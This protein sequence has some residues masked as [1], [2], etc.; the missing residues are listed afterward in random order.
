M[1]VQTVKI[2][3]DTMTSIV[4]FNIV[5]S[6]GNLAAVSVKDNLL[7]SQRLKCFLTCMVYF[8]SGAQPTK[9]AQPARKKRG[10]HDMAMADSPPPSLVPRTQD[11]YNQLFDT[12]HNQEATQIL[13]ALQKTYTERH[14]GREGHERV[15]LAD[16]SL[17]DAF[18]EE[19]LKGSGKTV[20]VQIEETFKAMHSRVP[21]IQHFTW[22]QYHFAGMPL[23]NILTN[24]QHPNHPNHPNHFNTYDD[25]I[26]FYNGT[27][28]QAHKHADKHRYAEEAAL[29]HAAK[30]AAV[31]AI[32]HVSYGVNP[33]IANLGT[34]TPHL[35]PSSF[36]NI[37]FNNVAS[38]QNVHAHRDKWV[39]YNFVADMFVFQMFHGFAI[40]PG[41]ALAQAEEQ[42]AQSQAHHFWQKFKQRYGSL[43]D[44]SAFLKAHFAQVRTFLPD[45]DQHG[46]GTRKGNSRADSMVV[47][48]TRR[49]ERQ[50]K[51]VEPYG[52]TA[53][54]QGAKVAKAVAKKPKAKPLADGLADMFGDMGFAGVGDA[55]GRHVHPDSDEEQFNAKRLH[56]VKATNLSYL[57]TI[58]YTKGSHPVNLSPE[59]IKSHK[60]V[61]L[62][63][64]LLTPLP[65]FSHH[66]HRPHRS[67]R[68]SHDGDDGDDAHM[69][70]GGHK[71][72]KLNWKG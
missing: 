11:A 27:I 34:T 46:G 61:E 67:P 38:H 57:A 30:K 12:P 69:R 33:S 71:Q 65:T 3:Y 68:K 62:L 59:N 51:T 28:F 43:K 58:K 63:Y 52:K 56:V 54:V 20:D 45:G 50:R 55:F 44:S 29:E 18:A 15:K 26:R 16:I 13:N 17:V 32:Q 49:S 22:K 5:F 4:T 66:P 35:Q 7:K 21:A 40:I 8:V 36:G 41:S 47:D 2:Y 72:L 1:R 53:A 23:V 31:D 9:S 24:P 37:T 60:A 48:P 19:F 10:D 39:L 6:D 42:L 70:G 64:H 25:Y 14:H